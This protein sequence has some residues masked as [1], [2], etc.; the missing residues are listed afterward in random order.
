MFDRIDINGAIQMVFVQSEQLKMVN[1]IE[2]RG[3]YTCQKE[4]L[5]E[6]SIR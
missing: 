6:D 5:L 4:D 1:D 3:V 2:K